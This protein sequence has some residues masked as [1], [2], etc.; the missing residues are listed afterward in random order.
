MTRCTYCKSKWKAKE[1]WALMNRIEGKQ[2]PY[3]NRKQYL[4]A[5]TFRFMTASWLSGIFIW[6]LPFFVELSENKEDLY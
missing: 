2:C 5:E 3:C 6:L 4:K 1:I